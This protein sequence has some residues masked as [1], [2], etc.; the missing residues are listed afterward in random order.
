M[1]TYTNHRS[2][3][4][5]RGIKTFHSGT[6]SIVPTFGSREPLDGNSARFFKKLT[7]RVRAVLSLWPV[8]KLCTGPGTVVAR[9]VQKIYIALYTTCNVWTRA[10]QYGYTQCART[11]N[12]TA[13]WVHLGNQCWIQNFGRRL[14]QLYISLHFPWNYF[15][16]RT[17]KGDYRSITS[18]QYRS[19]IPDQFHYACN[20]VELGNVDVTFIL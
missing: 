6:S 4:L 1:E 19:R 3:Q 10:R 15:N 13:P 7:K 12:L 9:R 11:L 18:Y 20:L 16:L 8:W 17:I 2:Q 5:S 14:Q